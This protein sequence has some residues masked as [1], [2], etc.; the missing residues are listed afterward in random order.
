M[1]KI[2]I[3]TSAF[4][5]VIDR[6]DNHHARAIKYWRQIENQPIAIYTTNFVFDETYTMLLLRIN[7]QSAL[8]FA[9]NILES[10]VIQM[11]YVDPALQK[12]ALK[13]A[14]RFHDKS[15]SFTDCTSFAVMEENKLSQAFAFDNH[16]IQAGFSLSISK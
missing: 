2:F 10:Q 8:E 9:K 1:D 15:F 11:I 7:H 5:A 13:I 12:K 14:E 4:V 16:F 6:S 3:D